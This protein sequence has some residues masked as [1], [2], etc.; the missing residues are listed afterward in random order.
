MYEV[1]RHERRLVQKILTGNE[2]AAYAAMNSKV[3]FVAAYPI[4]PATPVIETISRLIDEGKMQARF[5]SVESEHSAMA[6]CI[7]AS[8]AGVRAFTATSSHGLAYMHEMLHWAA[9]ARTPVV[10]AVANRAIGPGWNIWA[11]LS[12]S[13]SQRDTGWLQFY[14]SSIQEIYDTIA[15][16][17]RVAEN[18]RVMLPAMVCYDGFVLSHTSTAVEVTPLDGFID[19]CDP[20]WRID[21]DDPFTHG[22]IT[23]PEYYFS[24]RKSL[25]G[26]HGRALD[27]MPEVEQEFLEHSGRYTPLVY[28][29]YRFDDAEKVIVAMGAVASEAKVAVERLRGDN[30]KVGLLRLKSF[31]PFPKKLIRDLLSDKEVYVLDRALS[32]GVGGV[33]H[34]EISAVLHRDIESRILGIGGVDVTAEM[35]EK[36]LMKGGIFVEG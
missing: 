5:V 20:L 12:D 23:P 18:K 9:N 17:Y 6:A 21:F 10:M 13:L 8:A 31:R 32:P 3:R 36:A 24:L 35:I 4:T 14:C 34:Q 33:L 16:A 25:H 28:E 26:A 30:Q 22:N 1:V 2:A 27:L 11:D 19:E 29:N 7:G 15:M